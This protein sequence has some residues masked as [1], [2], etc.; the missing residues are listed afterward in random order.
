M[1]PTSSQRQPGST[2][3]P[4]VYATA[5]SQLGIS[6]CYTVTDVAQTISVGEGSFN[7]A[8]SWTPSNAGGYSGSTFTLWEAL[9]ESKNTASVY[10]MKQIGTTE[11]VR[12]LVHTMGIDSAS[13]YPNGQYRV[14]KQ[15]SI[16]LGATDLTV[17][18]M[19]GAYTTFADN[20]IVQKPYSVVKVVDK[21]GHIIYQSL[22]ESRPALP[23]G[24]NYV[25]LQMLKYVT[26]GA[27]GIGKLKS[28]VG[29]KT[30]TTNSYVDGW[31][32]GVTPTLVVGTWVG[33]EDNWIR[34]LTIGDGQGGAMARP[35]C[36]KFLQK[37]EASTKV[38]YY[39]ATAKFKTPTGD[40]GITIDC[41]QYTG[42]GGGGGVISTNPNTGS[43]FNT[44]R[45]SDE[46]E[47]PATDEAPAPAPKPAPTTPKPNIGTNPTAPKPSGGTTTK[48]TTTKPSTTPTPTA[49][50]PKPKPSNPNDDGFGG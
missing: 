7:L 48:P 45:F 1:E 5:I 22:P 10:L 49:P 35:F 17:L 21:K 8:R 6:P 40:I 30:G 43:E 12:A 20:G 11:P 26:K 15:P 9:K 29:G 33:G 32:M 38:I 4:F 18:E 13:K 14:P 24:A 3:K 47:A 36:A 16:C 42:Y 50:K 41:S 2:F 46:E 23:E 31:F 44:D 28:E 25:M 19:A 37:V 27:P 39:D 34:F